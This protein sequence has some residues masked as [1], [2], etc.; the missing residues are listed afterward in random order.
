MK[1][2][3]EEK[4]EYQQVKV[5]TD[6]DKIDIVLKI[7]SNAK[8]VDSSDKSS[9]PDFKLN[10]KYLIWTFSPHNKIRVRMENLSKS[11]NLSKKDSKTIYKILNDEN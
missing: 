4:G 5:I 2:I 8:W 11:T 7:F 6:K 1:L 10:N 9:Y 3:D